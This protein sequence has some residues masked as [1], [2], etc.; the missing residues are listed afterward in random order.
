MGRIFYKDPDEFLDYKVPFAAAL[1]G[2][3]IASHQM[4]SVTGLT[5]SQDSHTTTDVIYWAGGGTIG[6][7]YDVTTR[8]VSVGGRIIDNIDTF[9]IAERKPVE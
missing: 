5:I 8:V 3:P 7:A 9:I 1:A 4:V 2:D 6:H